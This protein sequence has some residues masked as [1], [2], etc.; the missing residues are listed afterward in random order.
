MHHADGTASSPV[1]VASPAAATVAATRV[2]ALRRR[3]RLGALAVAAGVI[4][5]GFW[6]PRLVDGFG[7]DV[8]MG[9][10]LG[11]SAELAEGFSVRGLSFGFLFAGLAG[12]AATFTACNCVV[13]AMVPG[14]ACASDQ[15]GSRVAVLKPLGLFIAA[16]LLVSASY[17]AVVGLLGPDGIGAYNA[18]RGAQARIVFSLIGI[19]MLAWGVLDLSQALPDTTL[20]RLRGWLS[21]VERRAS[22]M[23]LLVGLFGVGRP[24]PVMRDFLSY[25]ASAESPLYGAVVMAIEGLGQIAIMLVLL[26][27]LVFVFRKPLM[28][29]S[30]RFSQGVTIAPGV[31]LL[32]GGAFFLAYWGIFPLL[33]VGGWGFRLGWYS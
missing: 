20:G 29:W 14:L 16:V 25:A 7:R 13:F 21:P 33:D 28:R 2:P 12:L 23:G 10:T 3:V 32:G 27:G 30:T 8:V 1:P 15:T 17:G 18:A 4:V 9:Q 31:A 6:N 11:S 24:F 26:I 22:I 19:A 5:A